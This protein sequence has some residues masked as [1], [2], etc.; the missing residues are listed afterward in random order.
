MRV[1]QTSLSEA[2][3][4]MLLDY[5][6]RKGL[7]LKEALREGAHRLAMQDSVNK[8]DPIFVEEP[9]AKATGKRERTSVDPDRYLY[10]PGR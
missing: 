10:G 6:R 9:V 7:T 4:R 8:N 1:V 3:Y 5:A 2:E